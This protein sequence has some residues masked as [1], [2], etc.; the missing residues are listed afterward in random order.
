[1]VSAECLGLVVFR[2]YIASFVFFPQCVNL[3]NSKMILAT[4]IAFL[5]LCTPIPLSLEHSYVTVHLAGIEQLQIL[6]SQTVQVKV[7]YVLQ[8]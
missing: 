6:Q 8:L 3:V 4:H 2:T 5:A 7:P 1:M